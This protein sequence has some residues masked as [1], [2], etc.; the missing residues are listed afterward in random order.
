MRTNRLTAIPRLDDM[1]TIRVAT[2]ADREP[3]RRVIAAAYAEFESSLPPELFRAYLCDLLDLGARATGS[4][5]L[6]A[7]L[8]GEVVG[9]V[10]FYPDGGAAT[11]F[12]WP[13]GW[14]A[15]RALAVEPAHRGRG[16]GHLLVTA[17]IE[18]ATA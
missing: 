12:G 4:V 13:A 1:S 6:V 8:G 16:I 18:R 5:Q 9:A 11:G 3:L 14:A 17:C 10:T 15:L 2:A 7:D